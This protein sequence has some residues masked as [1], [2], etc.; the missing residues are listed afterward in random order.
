[1]ENVIRTQVRIPKE[2]RDWLKTMSEKNQ[3]SMNGEIVTQ[4][5]I[6]KSMTEEGQSRKA[7]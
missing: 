7:A 3:R 1:M 6:A 4:L 2:L 5:L